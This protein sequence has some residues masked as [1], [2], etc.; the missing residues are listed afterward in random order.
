MGDTETSKQANVMEL[1]RTGIQLNVG[2]E[3][4]LLAHMKITSVLR[5]KVLEAQLVDEGVGKIKE[6]IKQG[7]ELSLQML[8]GKLV[9]MEK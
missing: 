5:D 4:S 8:L 2:L 6:K 7:K 9:A 3:G 1:K